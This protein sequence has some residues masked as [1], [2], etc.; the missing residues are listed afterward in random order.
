MP[1]A[2]E[3]AWKIILPGSLLLAAA[4][5]V[6]GCGSTS[7]SRASLEGLRL[8]FARAP[9]VTPTAEQVAA[10]P[11]AQIQVVGPEGGAVLLLGNVDDG[12]QAFYSGDRKIVYLRDGLLSGSHGLAQ[13]A[14]DIRIE[15]DNPFARLPQ[16]QQ[17]RQVAR[18]YDWMPGYRYGVPVT[19]RLR[20]VGNTRMT[21][22]GVERDLLHFRETLRGPGVEATN[23]Y[24]ADPASGFIWKSRQLLAP[25][26]TLE[27]LQLKPYQAE[28]AG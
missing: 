25:G 3:N 12:R 2:Q 18:R 28:G 13:D 15:G 7:L 27:I 16:L 4:L 11:Y 17:P 1:P 20:R 10:S 6:A 23:D 22:L 14:A 9:D 8:A 5:L 26:I 19:G 24:W 21:I